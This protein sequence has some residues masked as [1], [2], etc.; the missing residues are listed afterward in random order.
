MRS[1]R[2]LAPVVALA[3]L[4]GCGSASKDDSAASSPTKSASSKPVK[5]HVITVS[6][7]EPQTDDEATAKQIL[8]LGG[9]D[10]VASGFSDNFAFPVD[11]KIHAT[12]GDGSPFYDPATK[13]VTLFY[14]F[15][16]T[17]A[18]IIKAGDPTMSDNDFGKAWAA[19]DAFILIHEL[20]HAFVDVFDIPIT[21]REEDA[22]DGMA[23]VFFTDY[24]KNGAEYA[25]DA[26]SF[27][28]QLQGMQGAP[29][30]AQFQDEH[31][32]SV[33]RAYDIVCSVAG[34]SD[35]TMQDIAARG[36]LPESRL[37]RCPA[38]YAQKSKAWTALLKPHLR[39]EQ[40][41]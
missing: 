12:S 15:V 27:F 7:D 40:K 23:T 16:N 34:S 25:F 2:Y 20:G 41:S 38:E 26:A 11:L 4:A 14:G 18:R 35:A 19:V 37:Q 3:L 13:T 17:T 5:K 24:V 29:D 6:Y 10:G 30:A 22:V 39:S 21:G 1:L 31:S 32:L 9:T 33:Q 8:Q 36:I 28:N